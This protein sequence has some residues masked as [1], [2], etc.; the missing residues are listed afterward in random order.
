MAHLKTCQNAACGVEFRGRA[1]AV[2]CTDACRWRDHAQKA[3][4]MKK[5]TGKGCRAKGARVEREV[6]HLIKA[7]TGDEV[8]RNLDQT[9]EGGFD[10]KWGPFGIE[11]KARQT[12]SMPEWQRQVT[13]AVAGSDLTPAIVWKRNGEDFWIAVPF[14]DF[15]ALF[16]QMRKA[17]EIAAGVYKQ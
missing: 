1:N 7:I 2:Y 6:C 5:L 16:D 3:Y 9:R 4:A 15:L 14:S 17:L 10:V 11:V 13:A 12:I 8:A